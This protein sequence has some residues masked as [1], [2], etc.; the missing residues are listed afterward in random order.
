MKYE[1]MPVVDV[2]E[3]ED[4]LKAQYGPDIMGDNDFLANL[5]F[6]DN[7]CNDCYKSYYF[8]CDEIYEGKSW[9]NEEHIRILNCLNSILRDTFPNHE[10]VIVDVSW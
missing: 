7:Y 2:Y 9:Q 10:R 5:M 3:L 1:M 6:Y 8:K 4:V